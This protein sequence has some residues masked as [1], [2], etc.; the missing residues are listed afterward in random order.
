MSSYSAPCMDAWSPRLYIP[1]INAAAR[2]RLD[3]SEDFKSESN[4]PGCRRFRIRFFRIFPLADQ[5]HACFSHTEHSD[6]LEDLFS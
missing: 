1:I 5:P 6:L 3:L 2:G 4:C